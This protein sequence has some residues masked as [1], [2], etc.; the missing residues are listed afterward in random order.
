MGLILLPSRYFITFAVQLEFILLQALD[1]MAKSPQN[2]TKTVSLRERWSAFGIDG[3]VPAIVLAVVLA[4]CWPG[5]GAHEGP[6]SLKVIAKYGISVV[7]FFYGLKLNTRQL[8]SDLGNWKLHLTVQLSTFVF[9]PILVLG[10]FKATG[11]MPGNWIWLGIFYVAALPSTVSSSVVM[12]SIARGNIPSA[13]FNA[14]LSSLIG[15][16]ITPLWMGLFL[17]AVPGYAAMS[18]IV[19]KLLLQILL[20]I[21][22][23]MLLNRWWGDFARKYS[24]KLRYFDQ[25]VILLI[26]YTAFSESFEQRLF[27]GFGV[28]KIGSLMVGMVLLFS[29]AFMFMFLVSKW[30]RF[31]REDTVTALFCG[32]K[33]SLMH[34]TVMSKVLFPASVAGIVLLPLML[35]HAFQLLIVGFI[36]SRMGRRHDEASDVPEPQKM[37]DLPDIPDTSGEVECVSNDCGSKSRF[38][39][40][41]GVMCVLLMF[42]MIWGGRR[43]YLRF[44]GENVSVPGGGSAYIFIPTGSGFSDVQSILSPFV[45]DGKAFSILAGIMK[46]NHGVK[47]GKY[48]IA[49][50]MSTRKLLVLLRSGRQTPV[51]VIFNSIRT[52][53]QFCGVIARQIESDSLAL[54]SVLSDTAY[55]RSVGFDSQTILAL[56][57]PDTYQLY[58]N[59]S[60]QAFVERMAREYKNFWTTNRLERLAATGL[61]RIEVSVLASILEEETRQ[62]DEKT[63]VAGLYI[64]RL[65]RGMPLQADPTIKFAWGDFTLRRILLRHL[66]IKSPYNTYIHTGLPPGPICMPSVSSIDAVLNY[67][68]HNYLY[69]CARE[70]FSGYHNFTTTLSQHLRNARRYQEALNRLKIK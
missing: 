34:G 62:E 55:I 15:V 42:F 46:Y 32:S 6:F 70:D 58:W 69:F 45:T 65:R 67:A 60:A 33:K 57:I 10:V 51:N 61:S 48:S 35:Y 26:I 31:S 47:P 1:S 44:F 54:L 22:L 63:L 43:Q 28:W 5:P 16:F 59:T 50:G 36:A 37:P 11:V 7:F 20:P 2:A 3:F 53:E 24:H 30:L 39:W 41:M 66:A 13:I 49:D 12:V 23:G 40:F 4:C 38:R 18:G 14:S 56:F 21:V 27:E 17:S 68:H 29:V 19:T 25:M 52:Q 9:F 64:N 8:L